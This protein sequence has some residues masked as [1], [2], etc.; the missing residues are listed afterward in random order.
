MTK[1]QQQQQYTLSSNMPS[2]LD[3]IDDLW[4][5]FKKDEQSNLKCE[6]GEIKG[7]RSVHNG[8]YVCQNCGNTTSGVIDS[9]AEWRCFTTAQGKDQSMVRCS[10]TRNALVPDTYNLNTYISDGDRR[11]QRVHQ[12]NSM[13]PK[14]R[15]MHSINKEL[16]ALVRQHKLPYLVYKTMCE[17]F[18][19]VYSHKDDNTG[20][21]RCNVRAG[22]KAACLFYACRLHGIPREAKEIAKM[23]DLEHKVVTRG[24]NDFCA[25]MGEEYLFMPPF[26]PEDFVERFCAA[27]NV[28][29]TISIRV[30]RVLEWLEEREVLTESCTPPGVAAAAIYRVLKETNYELDIKN[31]IETC[32]QSKT[33]LLKLVGRMEATKGFS[34]ALT[35]AISGIAPTDPV[36]M[37]VKIH[38]LETKL[39]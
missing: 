24:C 4:D 7:E 6:C 22:L 3:R 30:K 14:E 29:F 37:N 21:R 39:S 28:P 2:Q 19:T 16:E 15:T 18:C 8:F 13:T 38:D 12:W 27:L 1:S 5:M 31:I 10:D 20:V 35:K 36:L 25:L 11:L 23:M 26:R 32:D 33:V 34:D 17:M 9:A